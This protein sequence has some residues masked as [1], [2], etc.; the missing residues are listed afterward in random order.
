[1]RL[2]ILTALAQSGRSLGASIIISAG[3]ALT[4][5]CAFVAKRRSLG[6]FVAGGYS[7][8]VRIAGRR[9]GRGSGGVVTHIVVSGAPQCALANAK[10]R[11]PERQKGQ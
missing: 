8:D 5:L 3:E 9:V 7:R 6:G 2:S 11:L 1:M 10:E 4:G